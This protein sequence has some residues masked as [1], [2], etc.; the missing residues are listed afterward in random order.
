MRLFD[1]IVLIAFG[2]LSVII[3]ALRTWTK[4]KVESEVNKRFQKEL[5]DY[6]SQLTLLEE[7][8]RFDYQRRLQDFSLFI[9][10]KHEIAPRLYE[11]FKVAE[12]SICGLYGLKW[13]TT[14]KEFN[15]DDIAKYMT[16]KELLSGIQQTILGLWDSDREAA[17]SEL[18]K[19]LIVRDKQFAKSSLTE[20]SNYLLINELYLSTE[21]AAIAHRLVEKLNEYN[22]LVEFPPDRAKEFRD[23]EKEIKQ[24]LEELMTQLKKDLSNL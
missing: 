5:E 4:T 20:A 21:A 17:I 7:G 14:Y 24:A 13:A 11:L 15:R 19:S 18:S 12:G 1:V 23:I 10:K 16:Q 8:V 6:K 9:R 2:L 22:V 3:L